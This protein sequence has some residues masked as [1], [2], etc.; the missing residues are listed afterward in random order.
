[1]RG[2]ASATVPATDIVGRLRQV[3]PRR[4]VSELEER[5]LSERQATRLLRL[6]HI[7][8]P[9]VPQFVISALDGISV[10]RRAEWPTSGM[11]TA[12]PRGWRIVLA[13]DDA[14]CRQRFSLAHEFKH[15]LDDPLL[16]R[17]HAHLPAERR[18]DRAERICNH[19]AACLLMPRTW[20]KHDW[21]YGLQTVERLR[22]RYA[23]S[24]EAMAIRLADLGLYTPIR[25]AG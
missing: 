22:R 4:A 15:V 7:A 13:S 14:L 5:V 12:T 17:L 2:R 23:V 25:R 6:V 21:G 16:D 20:I 10:D 9:P 11:S 18:H 19:F 8:E 24:A 3:M 1:M